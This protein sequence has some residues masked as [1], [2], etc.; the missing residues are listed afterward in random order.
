MMLYFLSF[1][2]V[3]RLQWVLVGFIAK[4]CISVRTVS[5]ATTMQCLNS[6]HIRLVSVRVSD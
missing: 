3:D 4:M 5:P 1:T 6:L 2:E